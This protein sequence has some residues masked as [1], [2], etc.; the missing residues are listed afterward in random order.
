MNP[1]TQT[2]GFF[3]LLVTIEPFSRQA[4]VSTAANKR[5]CDRVLLSGSRKRM[6]AVVKEVQ[7]PYLTHRKLTM[8]L[9]INLILNIHREQKILVAPEQVLNLKFHLNYLNIRFRY[10][11]LKRDFQWIKMGMFINLCRMELTLITGQ[12]VQ[13]INGIL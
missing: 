3:Y 6:A 11:A 5:E 9:A 8:G 2:P 10:Q 13:L 12:E 1:G 4:Y 7:F